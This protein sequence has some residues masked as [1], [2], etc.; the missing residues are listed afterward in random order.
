MFLLQK[1]HAMHVNQLV[2]TVEGWQRLSPVS[3][4]KVG[5]YF[6]HTDP[7]AKA[8]VNRKTKNVF[9]ILLC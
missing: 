7:Q 4:D 1:S 2:V 8:P 5:I 6:R 9:R 3:V